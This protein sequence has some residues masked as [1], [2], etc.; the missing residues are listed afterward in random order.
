MDGYIQNTMIKGEDSDAFV[1]GFD[2]VRWGIKG[3][4]NERVDY[5]FQADFTQTYKEN[6]NSGTRGAAA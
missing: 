4:L 3:A 6:D 5:R 2:R 1:F